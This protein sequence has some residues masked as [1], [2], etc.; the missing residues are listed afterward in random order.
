MSVPPHDRPVAGAPAVEL[1]GITKRFGD[2]LANDGIDLAVARGEVHA[3]VG[4]NGAG[5]STLM[6]VLYGLHRPDAGQ[7]LRAGVPVRLRSPADA[8]A[9]GLGMVHQ[10]L[11]LFPGLSVAENVVIG[12][13]PVRRGMLDRA[14]ADRAVAGL[15]ERYGLDVDPSA[16]VGELP[17]GVRQRVEILKALY[18]RA[19]VLILDEP[20]AVLTPG[21][22]EG[23]LR[24]VREFAA[25][26]V[27]VL[28]VTHKLEE[29]L[30]ASDRVTVLRGGRVTG[31]FDTAATSADELVQAMIG[32]SLGAP[33]HG[34]RPTGTPSGPAEA[35][36]YV[37]EVRDLH[38][39]DQDGVAAVAEVSFGVRAG[40][41]VG[42]AGVAGSGQRELVEAVTGL[43]RAGSGEVLLEGRPVEGGRERRVAY[44]PADRAGRATAPIMSLAD[45]LLMGEQRGIRLRPDRMR[46]RAAALVERFSIRASSVRAPI[47]QLSGGNAQKAVLARELSRDTPV[48][49]VE[50]PTQGVDVG[51]QERIHA[52]LAEARD[53]G[54]AVLLQ[55]SELSEL[56]ALADRVLVMFE[57]RVVA[58][59]PV[60]EATDER[61]GAAMTGAA[62]PEQG[63]AEATG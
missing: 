40:E 22:T 13:E 37:L 25:E 56:R 6:S 44:V 9:H 61:L 55:S 7:V 49:V 53:A 1:A 2:V 18:R 23:L 33:P 10:R 57:G 54:R 4:E 20:T 15:S 17:V 63:D 32:R 3:V 11:R 5:K 58:D 34:P 52:L 16:R 26:G 42:L 8:I 31:R 48:L 29:V 43:R 24:M 28:L 50:E 27:S 36:A 46:Q 47:A 12:A 19:E 51:A 62:R 30:A 14:A 38:L 39:R 45:N 41:I 21:E 59:L 60:A 35:M